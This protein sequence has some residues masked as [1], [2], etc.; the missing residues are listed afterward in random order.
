M[1]ELCEKHTKGKTKWYFDPKNYSKEMGEKRKDFLEK[2]AGVFYEE[3]LIDG[4]G[5]LEKLSKTPFI[6]TKIIDLGDKLEGRLHGGQVIPLGDAQKILELCENPALLQC[7]CRDFVGQE[8]YYC[9]NFGLIP[10]LYEKAHKDAYIEEISTQKAKR[11]LKD[12]NKK[13]FYHTIIWSKAPYA[14]TVCN[15]TNLYCTNYKSRFVYGA[16]KTFVKGEY[17][18]RVENGKCN[19]CKIC[20]TRCQFGAILFDVEEEKAFINIRK[21]FGCGLCET[22]CKN[23][24]IILIDRTQTPSKNLW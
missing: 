19:G 17:V 2:V 22:H 7:P 13:G 21:C 6:N 15:C 14:T 23:G 5:K 8:K 3:W 24:A 11:F 10:E 16:K 12:L 20:L 9:L 4:C 18:A 1:C